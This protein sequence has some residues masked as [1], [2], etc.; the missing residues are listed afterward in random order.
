[1]QLS[2]SWNYKFE[3]KESTQNITP[4]LCGVYAG[5]L[6]DKSAR[7][8]KM[9]LPA[10]AEV[11]REARATGCGLAARKLYSVLCIKN[12][13]QQRRQERPSLKA[14]GEETP[15]QVHATACGIAA[16][17]TGLVLRERLLRSALQV[18]KL[19]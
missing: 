6:H 1:M 8:C 4:K 9:L 3:F 17:A 2:N 7:K 10:Q 13:L 12:G 18:E 14:A 16:R 5:M 19:S 11:S 15:C